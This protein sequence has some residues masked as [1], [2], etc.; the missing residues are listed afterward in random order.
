[1]A[2]RD[3]AGKAA[4]QG[5]EPHDNGLTTPSLLLPRNSSEIDAPL[6]PHGLRLLS[7]EDCITRQMEKRSYL[8]VIAAG[9]LAASTV[10]PARAVIL[11]QDTTPVPFNISGSQTAIN[12]NT[13]PLN[14]NPFTA[15]APTTLTAVQVK[16]VVDPV[17]GGTVQL[18]NGS[19]SPASFTTSTASPSFTFSTTPSL[20]TTGS[21]SL[22]TLNPSSFT[23]PAF[24]T[25]TV[26]GPYLGTTS[27]LAAATPSLQAYFA[28]APAINSYYANWSIVGIPTGGATDLNSATF[29]GQIYLSYQYTSPDPVP[30]PLPILGAGA[31]FGF[32]RKLR[33]RIRSSAG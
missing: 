17:F 20:S 25:A 6:S 27:P 26:S 33:Q 8:L 1:M 18:A 22:L 16:F 24:V 11:T 32:S 9:I 2:P 12:P 5:H 31:A 4:A 7:C 13:T 19:T 14:F 30:G 29:S 23:G 10:S 3:Q 21:A 15:S 28:S